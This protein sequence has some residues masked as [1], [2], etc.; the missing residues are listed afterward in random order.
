MELF[1]EDIQFPEAH[2]K[3]SEFYKIVLDKK[4]IYVY[5]RNEIVWNLKG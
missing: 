5:F 3:L 2:K 1:D 4:G